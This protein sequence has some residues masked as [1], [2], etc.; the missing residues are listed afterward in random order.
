MKNNYI[1]CNCIIISVFFL[2]TSCKTKKNIKESENVYVEPL[3]MVYVEGGKYKLKVLTSNDYKGD[4]EK[5][6]ITGVNLELF[7]DES[8][9]EVT[10][11]SYKISST[12]ITQGLYKE[13]MGTN[14]SFNYVHDNHPVECVSW[15]DAVEF[16]NKLSIR[17]GYTPCYKIDGYNVECNFEAEGYRLPTEAEWEYAASVGVKSQGYKYSGSN[18]FSEVSVDSQSNNTSEVAKFKP[19]ELGLYDMSGNV[20]EWCWDRYEF[21]WDFNIYPD[22]PM[23]NPKGI[24]S[25]KIFNDDYLRVLKGSDY[26]NG[27]RKDCRL[28]EEPSI[29]YQLYGFR[30]C[31]TVIPN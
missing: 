9:F 4:Y 15:Y 27:N 5:D 19:N 18:V 24:P 16:C 21:V 7:T 8:I 2:I 17:D 6:K 23:V 13:T 1:I 25:D 14:P 11:S 20:W 10:L 31:Q 29:T 30:I 3:N 12:E 26:L 28:A 22:F